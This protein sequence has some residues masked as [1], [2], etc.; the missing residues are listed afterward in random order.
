VPLAE[1]AEE[2]PNFSIFVQ[3]CLDYGI[4]NGIAVMLRK[5]ETYEKRA[6]EDSATLTDLAALFE[7]KWTYKA[8]YQEVKKILERD[9]WI[10]E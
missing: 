4:R 9:D 2:L 6:L 7:K 10:G 1:K 5:G 8:F 3:N